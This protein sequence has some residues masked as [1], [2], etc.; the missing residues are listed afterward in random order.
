[1]ANL[2]IN[3]TIDDTKIKGLIDDFSA[4]HGW[5]ENLS[6]DRKAM[7]PNPESKDVFVN[8]KLAEFLCESAKAYRVN[9]AIERL[10][11]SLELNENISTS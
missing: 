9:L 8:R 5:K 7:V 6:I 11:Q 3:L 1:M 2:S 4:Y 10:K